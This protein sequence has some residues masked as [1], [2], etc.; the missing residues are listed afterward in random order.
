LQNFRESSK[1]ISFTLE[2][3]E[4]QSFFVVFRRPMERKPANQE[5]D[6]EFPALTALSDI[7]GGWQVTFDP[8]WGG[9][10]SVQFGSLQDWTAH[11]DPGIRYYSGTATYRRE[12]DLPSRTGRQ[13][14]YLDLGTVHHIAEVTLNGAPVGVVWTAPWRIEIT[15]AMQPG[16]NRLEIAVTNVWA[17][18]LIGDE[19]HPADVTW[20]IGDPNFKSGY[21]LREFPDWF[22]HDRPRPVKER[23]TFTTWNYFSKDS[24]LEPSG[25]LGPVRVLA[26]EP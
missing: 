14:T 13:R 10:E 21:F 15:E 5:P 18:R 4:T 12:F 2:F 24:P 16:K 19:Q 6:K 25:L 3:A 22:L 7:E 9:P 26:E 11:A 20:Q 8:R 23:L 17:N 1:G